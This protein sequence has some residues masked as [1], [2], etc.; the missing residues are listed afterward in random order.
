MAQQPQARLVRERTV[1]GGSFVSGGVNMYAQEYQP[2]PTAYTLTRRRLLALGALVTVSR[3]A[4]LPVFAGAR[5]AAGPTRTHQAEP[6]AH[7]GSGERLSDLHAAV[8]I[9]KSV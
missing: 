4:P 1:C 6:L 3:L 9:E 2:A 5:R 8:P 7:G